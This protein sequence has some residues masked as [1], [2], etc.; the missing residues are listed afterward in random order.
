MEKLSKENTEYQRQRYFWIGNSV[1]VLLFLL[2]SYLF[3]FYPQGRKIQAI[4]LILFSIYQIVLVG[5]EVKNKRCGVW[6]ASAISIYGMMLTGLISCFVNGNMVSS[7]YGDGLLYECILIYFGYYMLFFG[8]EHIRRKDYREALLFHLCLVLGFVSLFGIIQFLKIPFFYHNDRGAA[9]LPTIN[10]NYYCAFP[11]MFTGLA[12]GQILYG[13]KNRKN[14]IL[15][16][17]LLMIGFGACIAA[18]SLLA[19]VGIIMILLLA[20][21]LEFFRAKKRILQ[22][23]LFPVELI[24]VILIFNIISHGIILNELLSIF[25]QIEAD[26]SIFGDSVGSGR[27]EIWKGTLKVISKNLLFGCGINQ[28][29]VF[30]GTPDYR[31]GAGNAHNEYLNIWAEQGTFAIIF[32]LVFLFSL[33]IPG[34]LQFIKEDRYEEDRVSKVVMFA[35]FGYIAQALSLI[36][37]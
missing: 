28:L 1:F 14:T 3:P 23:V 17:I 22:L 19:Y 30:F 15:W 6:N 25:I 35:F 21:F 29:L 7:F 12:V 24:A 9:I 16:N 10:Q 8:A 37:I 13:K 31:I 34:I 2:P 11:V 20:V 33:F 18:E 26:G 32:Y 5:S 36:H 27:M 4:F